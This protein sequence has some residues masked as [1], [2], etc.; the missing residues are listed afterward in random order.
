M[1]RALA[2]ALALVLAAP[3]WAQQDGLRRAAD[4]MAEAALALDA[5]AAP[6][7]RLDALTA[8]VAAHDDALAAL[9]SG[10]RRLALRR[11]ARAAALDRRE[12]AVA[13]L[14]GALAG[15]GRSQGP[16][17]TLHPQGPL[18]TARA[19]M[20]LADAAPA[21]R[22]EADRLRAEIAEMDRVGALE[23]EAQD[24]LSAGL[25]AAAA[26]RL[27]LSRA[28]ADRTEA[29][30]APPE[31]T[32]P[33][34]RDRA[35]RLRGLADALD[36]LPDRPGAAP[37][38]PPLPLPVAAPVLRRPGE[39]D[40]AGIV[41]PGLILAPEPGAT[42]AAPAA[43][44]VLHA[45]PVLD[46]DLVILLEVAPRIILVFAGATTLYVSPGDVVAAGAPLAAMRGIP[47]S[48]PR[49]GAAVPGASVPE[50]LYVEV[51]EAGRPADPSNWFAFE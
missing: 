24:A 13:R 37:L 28:V 23:R 1:L 39:A 51:R 43:G 47:P 35:A 45:G 20:L 22:A 10:L 49:D 48:A 3:A 8:V 34:L 11:D 7:A 44:T 42:V 41:R 15:L 30:V 17:S 36:A 2:L 26:A 25:D 33:A 19:G 5:A 18:G 40:A 38:A 6:G 31:A 29:L 32:A 9:R 50:T 12:K 16:L 14:L 4:R 27:A 21:L 46:Y